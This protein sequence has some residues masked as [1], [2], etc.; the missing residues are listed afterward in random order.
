MRPLTFQM[1]CIILVV[2]AV[3]LWLAIERA[4]EWESESEKY[5]RLLHENA[6]LRWENRDLK[7]TIRRLKDNDTL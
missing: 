4:S 7:R 3:L 6:R 1:I 5:R 2:D